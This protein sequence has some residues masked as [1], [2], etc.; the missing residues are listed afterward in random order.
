M[1]DT[2]TKVCCPANVCPSATQHL[3]LALALSTTIVYVTLRLAFLLL[4]LVTD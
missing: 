4:I 3:E 2:S 1:E